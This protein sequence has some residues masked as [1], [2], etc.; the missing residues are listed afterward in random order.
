M[1]I[2]ESDNRIQ[3]PPTE[4]DF[5]DVVGITGLFH[6]EFPTA[7]QQPRYDWM[8]SVLIGLLSNQS[9]KD[10]PTQK[11]TG[12]IWF[13]RTKG[14]FMYWTGTDWVSVANAI[15][16]MEDSDGNVFTL[17]EWFVEAQAKLNAVQP[18]IT[19]S[20]SAVADDVTKI[21]VPQA[22]QDEIETIASLVRPL[23]YIKGLLVDPRN[24]RFSAGCPSTVELLGGVNL[25]NGDRF[26]VIIEAFNLEITQEVVAS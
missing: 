8:R 12:T 1:A 14:I 2:S 23:V 5:A 3:F 7:G 25:D 22:V 17:L 16:V 6:D 11:R 4:V 18:K 26:T 19:F 9:S 13:N 15:S 21:P 20:G 10:P 24:S